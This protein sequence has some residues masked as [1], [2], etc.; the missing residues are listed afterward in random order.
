MRFAYSG[1]IIYPDEAA[2]SWSFNRGK[3]SW[4]VPC[5]YLFCRGLVKWKN[6][7]FLRRGRLLWGSGPV[8]CDLEL[9]QK[10]K[11]TIR[12]FQEF[13]RYI[14]IRLHRPTLIRLRHQPPIF[15]LEQ[16][17]HSLLW[18]HFASRLCFRTYFI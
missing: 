17:L 4:W 1:F 3:M 14:G 7:H 9:L 12:K 16:G 2:P 13:P 6:C 15:R 10:V 5:G 18:W 11:N 8:Y